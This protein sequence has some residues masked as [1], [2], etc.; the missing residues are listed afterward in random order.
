MKL[1]LNLPTPIAMHGR[2]GLDV[3]SIGNFE[4]QVKTGQ[5]LVFPGPPFHFV[6]AFHGARPRVSIAC[7]VLMET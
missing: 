1:A 4:V 3:L 7:N 5:L 2:P 6:H